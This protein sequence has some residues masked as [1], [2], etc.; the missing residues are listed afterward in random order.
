MTESV[1]SPAPVMGITSDVS[2][3]GLVAPGQEELAAEFLREQELGEDLEPTGE[4]G[5]QQQEQELLLGKFR[6][7]EELARAYQELE[8]KLGQGNSQNDGGTVEIPEYSREG[9]IE[10]YGELLTDKFEE[11]GVNPFEMAARFE[12]GEDLSPY[13]DKLAGAGIPRPVIEQYLANAGGGEA[14]PEVQALSEQEVE[15]FK[16][17]VGGDQAFAELTDWAKQNLTESELASYNQVV[18]GGNRQAIFWALRAM[19][20]QAA[21]S[22]KAGAPAQGKEPKLIGGSTPSDGMAFESMGQVL[23][24]M[25]KRNSLGQVL[26][27]TD[28]A[29]RSKVD[30]MVARSDFF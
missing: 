25:Q 11:A 18:D 10:Q 9:S 12:A 26:Y 28:D 3:N 22:K 16:G 14:Q 7:Q 1:F 4:T 24:A 5:A 30:A 20:L 6:S 19:S 27:E 2:P 8:R 13:V 17:M 29:Y 23:E 21:I 15:Q